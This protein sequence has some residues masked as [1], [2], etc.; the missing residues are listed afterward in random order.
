MYWICK[1]LGF[2]A[3]LMFLTWTVVACK[4]E[5]DGGSAVKEITGP[6]KREIVNFIDSQIKRA[7]ADDTFLNAI[8]DDDADARA[9]YLEKKEK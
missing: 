8:I 9:Q 5:T 4:S 6:Q 2:Y 3:L 1:K 7:L